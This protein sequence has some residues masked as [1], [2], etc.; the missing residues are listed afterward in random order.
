MRSR[1]L[2]LILLLLLPISLPVTASAETG[3]P[4][5]IKQ[6]QLDGSS[7]LKDSIVLYNQTAQDVSLTG[8]AIEY[9]RANTNDHESLDPAY[10]GAANWQTYATV[11]TDVRVT[12]IGGVLPAFNQARITGLDLDNSSGG[13]I[14]VI[15]KFVDG[16]STQAD[17]VGWGSDVSRAP[18]FEAAQAAIP[19][20]DFSLVRQKLVHQYSDTNNN[21]TDFTITHSSTVVDD[22]DGSCDEDCEE[23]EEPASEPVE[24]QLPLI[25]NEVLPDPKSP[26]T[27]DQHEFIEIYNPNDSAVNMHQYLLQT[28]A[29]LQY[30]HEIENLT[31]Q[32]KGYVTLF[33]ASTGLVLGNNA[34]GVR[35]TAA[36][37]SISSE[38]SY[39]TT[40]EGASWSLIDG[41]WVMTAMP[42]PNAANSRPVANEL[43]TATEEVS[44]ALCATGKERNNTTGRC[45]TINTTTASVPCEAGQERNPAT[46]RCRRT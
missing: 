36:D 32:A 46:Q 33:S 44:V 7:D 45:K 23:P 29:N 35:L 3:S 40:N 19:E 11:A 5:I 1:I 27:D 25:I 41:D 4:V 13:S 16:V 24:Q 14:R 10:C 18:C 6:V 17:L 26:Q 22:S 31:I 21:A 28:G 42:T 15:T 12:E 8:W 30:M 9:A 2:G 38:M 43:Q 39:T 34:G 37:G 20:T